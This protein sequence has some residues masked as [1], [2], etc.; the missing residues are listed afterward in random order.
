MC[1][2]TS[3]RLTFDYKNSPN[4]AACGHVAR[5]S[6]STAICHQNEKTLMATP[7][8]NSEH[9]RPPEQAWVAASGHGYCE[10]F[11]AALF[12]QGGNL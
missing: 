1:Q 12:V 6:T 5:H 8:Y 7:L 4:R 9:L 3:V 10:L 2:T 11:S